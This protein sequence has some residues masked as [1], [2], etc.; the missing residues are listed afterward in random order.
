VKLLADLRAAYAAGADSFTIPPGNYRFGTARRGV[1]SFVLEKMDRDGKTPFRILGQGATLWFDLRPESHPKVNYMVQVFD[2]ANITLEGLTIDS[3]PRGCMDARVTAF[4]FEGNRIQVEPLEGTQLLDSLPTKQNRFVPFKANGRHI[5]ALYNIDGGWGPRDVCYIGFSRTE[6]GKYWFE[7]E[8]DVLLKT[9]RDPAWLAT[10]GRE[11]TLEKGDVLTFLWSVSFSIDLRRCK[12]ITV[13]DCTVHAAKALSYETGYGGNQWLNCRFIPRSRTNNLLGGEGKMTSEC[14]VGSLVDGQVQLRTSDDAFMVRALWRHAVDV[15][16]DSITFHANVPELLAPGHKAEVFDKKSKQYIGRLTVESVEDRRTVCFKQPVGDQYADCTVLF[17]DFMN[18]GW[19]VRNSLFLESYQSTPLIQCGPGVFENNRIERAGAWVRITPGIPGKI[20]GGIANEVVFRDNVFVDSFVCPA[21]PGFF[22]NGQGS[23]S[24]MSGLTIEG[25]LICNTGREAVEVSGARDLVLKNNIVVNPFEG[26]ELIPEK[27]CPDLPAFHL[28]KVEGAT[29]ENNVVVRRDS[30]TAVT[31]TRSSTNVVEK[32]N[33][34]RVDQGEALETR[35]R[36]LTTTHDRGARAIIREVRA[37]L[38]SVPLLDDLRF[39]RGFKVW[40][41]VPGKK[42]E[43]AK[44]VPNEDHPSGIPAWG[45]A[46]W[47]SRF[48]LANAERELLPDGRIRFRDG[49]KAVTFFPP[50]HDIDISFALNGSTEYRGKAPKTG[51]PWPHL[52]AERKL[53]GHPNVGEMASLPLLICYR[54]KKAEVH[55]PDGFDPRRHT[56]Q[57]V[58]YLT[59]QNRNRQSG[60]FGDYY[61]FG[62]PLYDARYRIPKAHKAVDKGSDR[63]PA[64][65]KF[66]FNP[67][68]ERYTTQSAHDGDWVKINKDLASLIREGLETAWENGFLQ[69]SRNPADYRLMAMNT[70][71]EVTGP[72]DVEMELAELRLSVVTAEETGRD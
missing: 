43:Q 27:D 18:A 72:L 64:T 6:D 37:E 63:K 61:W 26:R 62:V 54:L 52:L 46:Q 57:F 65:G 8:T 17:A 35:I 1:A 15:T 3:D 33:Q 42:T 19:K 29:I 24:S 22:I 10:Y 58:F 44:I 13:R 49:A 55:R 4:D 32:D 51:A 69:D 50:G 67:G 71:W 28:K 25:N 48:T 9:I 59:V 31:C 47:H 56:A 60:G 23:P 68:G 2:C 45:L 14:M 21:N 7:M 5:A 16:P 30:L 39:E 36:E 11:G 70:G 66:I 41:P 40:S 20:E 12:E 38:N 53:L 34:A